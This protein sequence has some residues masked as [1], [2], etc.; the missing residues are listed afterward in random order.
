MMKES[1]RASKIT[2]FVSFGVLILAIVSALVIFFLP[3]NDEPTTPDPA[4]S[5]TPSPSVSTPTPDAD[6]IGCEAE[7]NDSRAVP[8]DLRWA[9]ANGITWPVSDTVGP[10]ATTDGFDACFGRGIGRGRYQLFNHGAP[11][12]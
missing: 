10:T 5:A 7:P 11:G 9:A 2:M 6:G 12:S 8:A 1:T 4:G 3:T